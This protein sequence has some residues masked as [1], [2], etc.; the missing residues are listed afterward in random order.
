MADPEGGMGRALVTGC[1]GF[2]GSTLVDALLA[3]G[4]RVIGIDAVTDSYAVDQKRSNLATATDDDAF[5]LHEV[6]LADVDLRPFL[7][8][9][10]VVFH[11]AGLPGV[12]ASWGDRFA[13]Y[14]RANVLATQRLLEQA[15]D[16][17]VRRI[18]Y[19]SSSSVYGAAD[20]Y[21]VVETDLPAPRSP[22]GVTK[23]AA[24]HLCNL[25]A[26]NFGVPTVSLRYFTVYGPRQRPDMAFHRIVE[27]AL[28]GTTFRMFGT[29]EQRRDF[30]FVADA[31]AANLLAATTD[32]APGTVLNI[33]GDSDASM[34]D[35]VELVESA[36]GR[37]LARIDEAFAAGDVLRTGADVSRARELIGWSPTT[38]LAD[39]IGAQVEWHRRRSSTTRA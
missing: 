13:E 27:A 29:G 7:E 18:V 23:L 16:T 12:R 35:V 11:L 28:R 32:V 20:R 30:T 17:S 24:E 3:S 5:E 2:I 10:D 4:S 31:V 19:S 9:V 36:T 26:A 14:D 6:D 22:Y 38:T 1:A 39:G 25:Y 33:G 8:Q 37:S 21:P 34:N 15:R